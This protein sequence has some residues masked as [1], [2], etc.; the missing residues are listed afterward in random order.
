MSICTSLTR[1]Q[2]QRVTV[3][4]RR[5]S[6]WNSGGGTHGGTYYK[7]PAVEAK[8]HIFLH[9]NASNLMLKT[10]QHEKI[11]GGGQYPR[12]KFWGDL[13]PPWSTP[14]HSHQMN[15]RKLNTVHYYMLLQN[16][17]IHRVYHSLITLASPE[18][19]SHNA[20]DIN[21]SVSSTRNNSYS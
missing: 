6:D 18:T 7:S 4:H 21:N 10:W 5:T 8:K 20:T 15:T 3:T 14:M 13:S 11:W 9:C 2:S 17:K 1:A 19:R 16:Y 12:S